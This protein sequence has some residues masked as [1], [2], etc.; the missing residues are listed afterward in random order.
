MLQQFCYFAFQIRSVLS[1][2]L[3][4]PLDLRWSDEMGSDALYR[5]H[6]MCGADGAVTACRESG[7]SQHQPL[8]RC[9]APP[10]GG[11]QYPIPPHQCL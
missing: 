9:S 8:C 1:D 6:S 2:L 5:H 4:S 11:S 10:F 3:A 7:A